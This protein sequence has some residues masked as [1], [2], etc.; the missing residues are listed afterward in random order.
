MKKVRY[1]IIGVGNIGSAYTEFFVKGMAIDACLAAVADINPEKL[2]ALKT[3]FPELDA[4]F[5]K[6][7]KELIEKADVDAVIV[8]VPH[9][10]H[11]ELSIQ[12]LNK[13]INVICEKPAG[14]YTKQVKEMNAVAE[15]S[16]ALFTVMFSQRTNC[17]Y[18][19]MKEMIEKGELGKVRRLNWI[20]TN[21]YRSQS[22]YD[23]SSWRA[24]WK[25][26]GGGVLFNQCPHQLDLLQ[27]ITGLM[28][29][30]I[31]AFCEYG[32]WHNIEVEDDVTAFL[33][34]EN[35]ATGVFVTTTADTPGT[36]RLEITGDMGRLVCEGND[37]KF[38]KLKISEREFN[39]TYKGGFGEPEK[40]EIIVETDGK[41]EQHI[42]IINN[43]TNAILGR[44]PLFIDGKE[45]L[46][47]V[48]I[49][50]AMSMSGWLGGKAVKLPI[51]DDKY[52]R[53]L[54]EKIKNSKINK[55]V[56][57]EKVLRTSG[58]Y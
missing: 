57:E 46:K 51:D 28:P 14:V 37:L 13:N 16:K 48:E 45:G 7:G 10:F 35:G 38:T 42:G 55:T 23:S 43:F 22:Y 33:R 15:K 6:S 5:Y 54:K 24:T 31:S 19:K 39:Q 56:E 29:I 2:Q 21:W 25:G 50:D 27:W 34:F 40:E 32:K 1:G 58:T 3:K 52:L 11:P 36:N 44:E 18:R 4:S 9:Y 12:A 49:M 20:I 47:S 8:A 26:E 30:E 17:V 41:N 53:M